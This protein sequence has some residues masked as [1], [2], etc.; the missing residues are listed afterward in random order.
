MIERCVKKC[1]GSVPNWSFHPAVQ[2]WFD[3]QYEQ[4]TSCQRETWPAVQEQQDVLVAAPTGS[5]K[6]LAAFLA[7]IDELVNLAL[8]KEGLPDTTQVVYVSPLKALSY[9]IERNLEKPL[10][11]IRH[12]LAKDG[13]SDIEIKTAVRTG[14]TPQSER[15]K[16][17]R[18]PPHILVTTPESF[19]L[20]LTSESGR[21]MLH[22][23]QRLIV[24]EIHAL[25]SNKRGAHFSLSVA[26][27]ERLL[28]ASVSKIGLSATQK[29]VDLIASFLTGKES[30]GCKI[31]DTGHVREWDVKVNVPSRP[32]EPVM[33]NESW[34]EVYQQIANLVVQNRTTLIFVNTRRHVER[35]AR[36]L[37]ELIGKD[38]VGSHHGSLSK[39]HRRE[40]EE[41]LKS[42]K[43]RALVASASMELGID[44]GEID[45]VCQVCSP[46]SIS[47]FLQRIGRSGHAVGRVPKGRIFPTTRDELVESVALLKSVDSGELE[48]IEICKGA[49]DVLA[50]QVVAE[51]CVSDCGIDELLECFRKAYPYRFFDESKYYALLRMLSEGF[52]FKQGN[53]N[54]HIHLDAVNRTI[55]AKR[56]TK[57]TAATNAGVIPDQFDYDVVLEPDGI[58]IGTLNE[59]FAFE[60][61]TGDIFQLG[62]ASYRV[63][64]VEKGRV[65]VEDAKGLPPNIPFWFGE[66]RGRS[67]ALNQSVSELREFVQTALEDVDID[68]TVNR[69]REH[70]PV[71]EFVGRQIVEYLAA[72]KK[73]LGQLPTLHNIVVERFFD[74]TGDAHV[75]VHSVLG[76][77]LNRAW[78]LAL[79]KK[80]CVR[81]NFELQAAALEDNF[82]LS[83]GPTH[84]FALEEIENY[85]K[86]ETVVDTLTQAIFG[87]P[88]FPVRWR[89]VATTALALLRFKYG[90]KVPPPLQ[91]N[92][93][94]D[95]LSLVFPD[96]VACQENITGPIS[97]PDH[98]LVMQTI[99]DCLYDVMD[100]SG[101]E[102]V[103]GCIERSEIEMSFLDL[104]EASPLAHEIL[105]AKPYAF[106]DDAPAEE[107]RTLA[108][109]SRRLTSPSDVVEYGQLD[110]EVIVEL[111]NQ[112][113]PDPRNADEL[114]EALVN[115]GFIAEKEIEAKLSRKSLTCLVSASQGLWE[116]HFNELAAARR[117]TKVTTLNQV[118]LWVAAERLDEIMLLHFN[119]NIGPKIEPVSFF[120]DQVQ[121]P[122]IAL[123]N[124]I[125]SRLGVIGPCTANVLAETVDVEQRK[126]DQ[127]LLA[128]ESEGSVMKGVFALTN[129]EIE[130]CERQFLARIH[131]GTIKRL[132]DQIR[133]VNTE[134]YLRYLQQWMKLSP[135]TMG[136]GVDAL[137]SVLETME[138]YE[139]PA[140]LWES[141]L[142]PARIYG[143]IP[144]LLDYLNA[145]GRFV[146]CRLSYSE[147]LTK[148][149]GEIHGRY[150]FK[151]SIKKIPLT[152]LRR[153]QL[154][155]WRKLVGDNDAVKFIS[156]G[157]A[158]SIFEALHDVGPLF[159]D[160]ILDQVS[161]LPSHVEQG[162]VELFAMGKVTCDH[163]GGVRALLIP[164]RLRRKR[165]CLNR[166]SNL[167]VQVSGRWSLIENSAR[168]N[169]SNISDDDVVFEVATTLLK[170]WGIIYRSLLLREGRYMPSWIQLRPVF[171]RL[172]DQGVVRGGRFVEGV[173]GEQFAH[174]QAIDILR[175]AKKHIPIQAVHEADPCN[176]TGILQ[177]DANRVSRQL[178][179]LPDEAKI[180][181][182]NVVIK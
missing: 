88:M 44:V 108:V 69:F 30:H 160:E 128:L 180:S 64:R 66:G 177:N 117:A 157:T 165:A 13:Y 25:A 79:R 54:A 49:T 40:V 109:Q 100:A 74:E 123:T 111:C 163:Y 156:S 110:C 5:G 126:V 14:D 21:R 178:D 89:W 104:P 153:S 97:V 37:T 146:W 141:E 1:Q 81:F 58:R 9:D 55:R 50:Q 92:N 46:R 120:K 73:A 106:L 132:R 32:L 83:L 137:N 72:A 3:Q 36:H 166:I 48:S 2:A 162:L 131:R 68:T 138:A 105:T 78:G 15:Q 80:F 24:D 170:R 60:S 102:K 151:G 103:L 29:P 52:N 26:R 175:A 94:E 107:R 167:G 71:N 23:T 144:E 90:K 101:L 22:S 112:S 133:P 53:R 143:Y 173:S 62:N 84:S 19:Y 114:H 20:L 42:G 116:Q 17:A 168:G 169:Y 122:E 154:K 135:D 65:R 140:V 39:E 99:S 145:S 10:A 57:I 59:D 179:S 172:E 27:L 181:N 161:L 43:L 164:E 149:N 12:Q 139:A 18:S 152:F 8:S 142:L 91:R 61:L 7:V 159:F 87:A 155:V 34:S 171:R 51:A 38:T 115:L 77:Q 76:S 67:N 134:Q 96:Q 127:A 28:N 98:P 45:L 86:S 56:G 11:G 121:D 95:L 119:A 182:G 16:M 150:R 63:L 82:V 174:P 148:K 75:V 6:T 136:E 85:V 41:K 113:W 93:A 4:A 118:N 124:L 158:Q 33:S 35:A 176:L 125:R 129:G 31:V 130:W 70:Y 47:V 147:G